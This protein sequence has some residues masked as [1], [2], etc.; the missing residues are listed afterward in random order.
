MNP[1]A[2]CA[3]H[4]AIAASI[5]ARP[6]Y[7]SVHFLLLC[8]CCGPGGRWYLWPHLRANAT[9][10]HATRAET[11]LGTEYSHAKTQP[12]AL[13]PPAPSCPPLLLKNTRV[14]VCVLLLLFLFLF[15]FLLFNGIMNQAGRSPKTRS[16]PDVA[17]MI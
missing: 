1:F 4:L 15:L 17:E 2:I 13:Q 8:A 7:S 14:C 11:G 6:R 16:Q 12:T 3:K 10:R 5:P 9:L